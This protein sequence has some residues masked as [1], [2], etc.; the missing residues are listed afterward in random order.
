MTGYEQVR[1]AAAALTGDMDAADR[2][3]PSLPETRIC[4]GTDCST[5]RHRRGGDG[6]AAAPSQPC[7]RSSSLSP[8]SAPPP[9]QAV[10]VTPDRAR[11]GIASIPRIRPFRNQ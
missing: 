5:P 7:S 4:D 3:E 10:A 2:M 8:P 9:P 11:L 1:S 6:K